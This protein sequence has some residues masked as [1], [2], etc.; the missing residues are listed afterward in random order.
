VVLYRHG[1][2]AEVRRLVAAAPGEVASIADR[3][4]HS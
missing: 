4:A 2:L 1:H 3:L